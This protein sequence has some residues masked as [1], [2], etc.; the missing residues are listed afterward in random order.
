MRQARHDRHRRRLQQPFIVI[1]VIVHLRTGKEQQSPVY[2]RR[3]IA[4]GGKRSSFPETDWDSC[5]FRN[6][7]RR[8]RV[9]LMYG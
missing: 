1:D 8:L 9:L 5:P 4:R 6:R 7:R 2:T 3:Y